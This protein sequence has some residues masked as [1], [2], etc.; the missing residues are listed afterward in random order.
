M[1]KRFT[2]IFLLFAFSLLC[3]FPVCAGAADLNEIQLV[4]VTV[5][6]E[7]ADE[8]TVTVKIPA[9]SAVASG[10]VSI[11]YDPAVFLFEGKN[12][13]VPACDGAMFIRRGRAA[14]GYPVVIEFTDRLPISG[15]EATFTL[16]LLDGCEPGEYPL[17]PVVSAPLLDEAGNNSGLTVSAGSVTLTAYEPCETLSLQL[18]TDSASVKPG[19]C[20]TVQYRLA[21]IPESGMSE[22]EF[23]TVYDESK[24]E[25]LS[26]EL[27]LTVG[28][29]S[30]V[31]FGRLSDGLLCGTVGD[32]VF[33]EDS[34]IGRAIFF[35]KETDADTVEISVYDCSDETDSRTAE[36]AFSAVVDGDI[37]RYELPALQSLS[38]PVEKAPAYI[39]YDVNGDGSITI[40]DVSVLLNCLSSGSTD[41]YPFEVLDCNGD[42]SITI[43]DVSAL[44]NALGQN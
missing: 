12:Q 32:K 4:P 28:G 41:Q 33:T 38:I 1:K 17:M 37:V 11:G 43:G 19:D 23:F 15:G 7:D 2:A 30:V 3:A 20:I 13:V 36:T 25:L 8:V 5:R 31:G 27:P 10:S 34:V 35:V 6:L 44:L 39:P 40:G 14:D 9:G 22:Y 42:G 24:L 26:L 16:K 18:L 29:C 21:G